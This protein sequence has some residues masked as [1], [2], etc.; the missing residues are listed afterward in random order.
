MEQDL[1]VILFDRF[2]QIARFMRR[3]KGPGVV[4]GCDDHTHC[5][6]ATPAFRREIILAILSQY[7]DGM[8]Q[9]EIADEIHVSPSTM[10]E[11]IR[12]L[13]AEHYIERKQDPDDGRAAFIALTH[14]GA[15]RAEEIKEARL[16]ELRHI[17]K[18]LDDRD[19]QD[20]IRIVDKMFG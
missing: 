18:N 5:K 7:P 15:R 9:K 8:R 6:T 11:M 19:K 2:G 3:G 4:F 1:D 10:S 14:A 13:E 12:R 17:F 20:L 16:M